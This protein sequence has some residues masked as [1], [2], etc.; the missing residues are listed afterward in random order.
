[1]SSGR[2]Q[3]WGGPGTSHRASI[4]D[5]MLVTV[6]IGTNDLSPFSGCAQSDPRYQDAIIKVHDA[7]LRCGKYYGNAGAQYLTGYTGQ[8]GLT[9]SA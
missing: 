4:T 8:H 9:G 1:V 5:N 6:M 3:L 7:A 2:N